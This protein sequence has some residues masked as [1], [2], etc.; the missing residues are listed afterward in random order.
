MKKIVFTPTICIF[1]LLL[2][3][4]NS[5]AAQKNR[6]ADLATNPQIR[7]RSS[8]GK[9]NYIHTYNT[10][11]LN[12]L[13]SRYNIKE[14]GMFVAGLSYVDVDWKVV[15]HSTIHNFHDYSCVIPSGID[16]YLGYRNPVIYLSNNLKFD[17]CEYNLVLR[18]EQQHHQINKAVLDY[19][20][21]LLR[22]QFKQK[23]SILKSH[24]IPADKTADD[25]TKELNIIYADA[26]RPVVER[27][28]ITL[29]IEQSRLDN[30]K[31]Y[32]YEENLCRKFQGL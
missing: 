3:G 10:A 11:Q 17:T 25:I 28:Q 9:L 31:N 15:L 30:A 13:A 26:I 18:H 23:L 1:A 27:F 19:Y 21:P 24:E 6:C 8:Y 29:Q 14:H 2:I 4:N 20:L 5:I 12:S 32:Q 22:T 7:L 16:I